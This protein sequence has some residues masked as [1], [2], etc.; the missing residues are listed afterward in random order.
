MGGG[1]GERGDEGLDITMKSWGRGDE[2]EGLKFA[3]G[4]SEGF[5]LENDRR[6]RAGEDTV[7][8]GEEGEGKEGEQ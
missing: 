7:G 6:E 4:R 3:K 8:R 1:G 2:I 5:W